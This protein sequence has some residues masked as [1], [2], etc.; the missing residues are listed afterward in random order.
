TEK[1]SNGTS[2]RVRIAGDRAY[3]TVK[4]RPVGISRAEFEYPVPVADAEDMLKSF[5]ESRIIE[6]TR[7]FLHY[8]GCLWEVD[9]FE[10]RHKGLAVAE[11]ELESE[12]TVF[13]MPPF[14]GEE[15]T[16]D[17]RYSNFSLSMSENPV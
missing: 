9:V 13:E 4:G 15:V 14:A 16:D 3:L 6:K 5:C 11:I 10:G 12:D 2:F 8:A 17:F 7:Y 1:N